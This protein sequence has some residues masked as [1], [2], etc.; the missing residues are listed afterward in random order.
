MANHGVDPRTRTAR[1][2]EH[3]L[4]MRAIWTQD[5]ASFDGEF[6]S[7]ERIWSWPKPA[8]RL[9]VLIGGG[10]PAVL[11]RVLDYGDGWIPLRLP[12]DELAEFGARIAELR[13]RATDAGRGHL[14]VTLYGAV[15]KPAALESYAAAGVDRVLF[16]LPDA[17]AEDVLRRLDELV[18]VGNR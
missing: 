11:D 12:L 7:F 9:P 14:P 17:P 10:G 3:V 18:V 2:R 8:G 16:E 13:S 15:P 6:V 4:A 1:M 5:E